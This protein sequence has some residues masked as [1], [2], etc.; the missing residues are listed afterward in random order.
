MDKKSLENIEEVGKFKNPIKVGNLDELKNVDHGKWVNIKGRIELKDTH[1]SEE[2]NSWAR[3]SEYT[4]CIR[5][6]YV[7]R[8]CYSPHTSFPYAKNKNGY[9]IEKSG[10]NIPIT[11]DYLR[12]IRDSSDSSL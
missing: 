6:R 3:I 10:E 9:L 8:N 5:G 11:E 7:F 1:T 12:K 4:L 2:L